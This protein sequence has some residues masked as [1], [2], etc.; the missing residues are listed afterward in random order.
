[1]RPAEV[2]PVKNIR[3]NLSSSKASLTSTLPVKTE[4]CSGGKHSRMRLAMAPEIL[5]TREEG[6]T[7]AVFPADRAPTRGVKVRFMG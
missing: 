6:L 2:L 5:G 7:M 3:S 4:T 1:M